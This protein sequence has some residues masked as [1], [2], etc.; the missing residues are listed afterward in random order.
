MNDNERNEHSNFDLTVN[1]DR[2]YP[3]YLKHNPL[4]NTRVILNHY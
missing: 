2:L 3:P 4:N 1:T